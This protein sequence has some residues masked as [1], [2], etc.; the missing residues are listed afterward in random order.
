MKSLLGEIFAGM[1]VN[2]YVTDLLCLTR[3]SVESDAHDAIFGC[4]DILN[5]KPV[6]PTRT[7]FL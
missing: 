2:K 5:L 1:N 4:C 3:S 7:T 6:Y